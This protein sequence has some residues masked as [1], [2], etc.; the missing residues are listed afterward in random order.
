MGVGWVYF[1]TKGGDESTTELPVSTPWRITFWLL[2]VVPHAF[3]STFAANSMVV[4]FGRSETWPTLLGFAFCL[5]ALGAPNGE[6]KVGGGLVAAV[7]YAA[8]TWLL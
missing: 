3:L 7:I 6:G 2:A 1:K 4:L 8:L 5:T